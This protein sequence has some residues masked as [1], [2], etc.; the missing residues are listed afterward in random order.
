MVTPNRTVN[1]QCQMKPCCHFYSLNTSYHFSRKW[2]LAWLQ[3]PI[4]QYLLCKILSLVEAEFPACWWSTNQISLS[5]LRSRWMQGLVWDRMTR[6]CIHRDLS[7]NSQIA[8][9][10]QGTLLSTNGHFGQVHVHVKSVKPCGVNKN[11]CTNKGNINQ[12][13]EFN[14]NMKN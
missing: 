14:G 11:S 2:G 10:T 12:A 3:E 8:F 1:L 7:R 6:N 9:L 4:P 13:Q 5:L